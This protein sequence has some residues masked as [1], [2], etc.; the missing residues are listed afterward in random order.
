MLLK[1]MITKAIKLCVTQE[2]EVM[3]CAFLG[4]SQK[5]L[6]TFGTVARRRCSVFN[7]LAGAIASWFGHEVLLALMS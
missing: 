1:D 7:K 6:L 4:I 5:A 2:T 3:T